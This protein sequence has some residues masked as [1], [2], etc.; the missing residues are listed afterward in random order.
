[1][2]LT[3]FEWSKE[4][5]KL[6]NK[7]AIFWNSKSQEMWESGSRK[8]ILPFFQKYVEKPAIVC[9]LGCGDGY[10]SYK[11]RQ[12]DYDVTGVDVSE[13]MIQ[14]ANSL[15]SSP[16]S[17]FLK[18]DIRELAFEENHFDAVLAIN[19]LEW[20][21][22]PLKVILEMKRIVK[23]NGKACVA[24]LG[25]TAGPRENSFR[26]LYGEDVICNTMMPWEFER[27]AEE[28]GWKKLDE[29]WVYKK[30]SEALPKGSISVQMKEALSFISV[31]MLENIK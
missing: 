14:K 22:S 31:F 5:E 8:D 30:D 1:M 9:D 23:A 15:F 24:I 26:R 2:F 25:P 28:N 17:K 21:E 13:E 6:W 27:L 18:G 7:R 19:S 10:G 29:F 16:T 4:A 20:T 12:A 3:S 11:L